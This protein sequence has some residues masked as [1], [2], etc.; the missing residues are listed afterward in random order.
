MPRPTFWLIALLPALAA[1]CGDTPTALNN[2]STLE[3]EVRDHFDPATTGSLTGQVVWRGDR[4]VVPTFR[5][6]DN[7]LTDQV[8]SP[9]RD[10]PNPNAPRLHPGG[11]VASAVVWL[12]GID[13]QQARPWSH[14][15]VTVELRGQQFQVLQG[16]RPTA[17]GIVRVGGNFDIVSREAIYH[18][19]QGRGA[20][21]FGRTLPQPDHTR[22]CRVD[23]P[24]V[25]ELL[26]G[27]GYYWMR[28]HVIG[29]THPY[30]AATDAEGRFRLD[31]VPA[32]EYDLVAWHPDWQVDSEEH[33][34]E[35]LRVQQVRFAA[36]LEVVRKV[37]VRPGETIEMTLP[38]A[39]TAGRS[40]VRR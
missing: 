25:V 8:P 18:V 11:G 9:A 7:P 3:A 37:R 27:C 24:G 4:P 35:L 10:W 17:I 21:F 19:V 20:A 6:I 40:T 12:R 2:D 28:A 15:P 38:L 34:T 39:T 30:H 26:S 22:L 1:G 16:D 29:A 33:N 13:P 36:P 32:G 23:Q 14:P 31:Q 5:S